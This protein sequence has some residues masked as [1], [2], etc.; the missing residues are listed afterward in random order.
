MSEY[1]WIP[2]GSRSQVGGV[3]VAVSDLSDQLAGG[4]E[5]SEALLV[6]ERVAGPDG[7]TVL[8]SGRCAG[9]LRLGAPRSTQAT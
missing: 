9:Y 5:S 2:A 8:A 7:A 1:V 3:D 6:G 4:D